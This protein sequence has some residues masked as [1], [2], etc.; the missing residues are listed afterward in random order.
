[1]NLNTAK[2]SNDLKNFTESTERIKRL[3]DEVLNAIPEIC[4]ERGLIV[5]QA[6]LEL[7]DL[8]VPIKRA[9]ILERILENMTISIGDDELIVGNQARK[10]RAAPLFPEYSVDWIG[11]ELDSF[12]TRPADQF[13]VYDNE[14]KLIRDM[15]DYW[16]GKTNEDAQNELISEEYRLAEEMGVLMGI[17]IRI[18]GH[19]HISASH[20]KVMKRGLRDIA[21]EAETRIKDLDLN[22]PEGIEKSSFLQAVVI[23]CNA[24][25]NFALRYADL[26]TEMSKKEIDMN[27]KKELELIAKNCRQVPKR[28]PTNFYEAVQTSW[29][30]Q[31][32]LQI[33]G[34]GHSI[35]LGRFDQYTHPFYKKSIEANEIDAKEAQELIACMFIKMKT[36]NKVRAWEHAKYATGYPMY[37]NLTIGGQTS[38]GEDAV[39]EVTYLCINAMENVRFPEPN[40]IARYWSGSS[41]DY[42]KKCVDSISLGFGMPAMLNDEIIIPSLLGRGVKRIDAFN[43]GAVGCIEVSIPGKWGYR[44]YGMTFTSF[45]KMFELM[46]TNGRA[47]GT[48]NVLFQDGKSLEEC[49]SYEELMVE[50]KRMNDVFAKLAVAHDHIVD[51]CKKE[52]PEIFMSTLVD[53][54][55]VR[56]KPILDGG[57]IYDMNSGVQIGL[58]NVANSLAVI[59]KLV[60]EEKKFTTSEVL[61]VIE[62]NFEGQNG[63]IIRQI[64]KN[65]VPKYGNDDDYVDDIAVEVYETYMDIVEELKNARYGKGP[66]GGKYYASTVTVSANVPA[67]QDVGATPDGRK[68]GEPCAE[69]ASPNS[70]TDIKGPTSVMKSITKIPTIRMTGGQ[71]LNLKFSPELLVNDS[72]KWKLVALLRG[73]SKLKGWHVQ[74]NTISNEI[75]RNAQKNPKDYKNL[76]VRVAGYCALFTDLD[77]DIQNEIINRTEHSQV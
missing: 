41:D 49:N 59:K 69:G 27:R 65:S 12:E 67:G 76:M 30:I 51:T 19:G 46:L 24:V 35:S 66:I 25:I 53:D 32:V 23:G 36:I 60:F 21:K 45:I 56:G 54:C 43:Y 40:L 13:R 14:K 37:Q 77:E 8:P 9:K 18:G 5:T 22:S 50:W 72:G 62:N 68:A 52:I 42:L 75:L 28:P 4:I 7:G 31:L 3:K 44:C 29:F 11:E 20:E 57:A 1:M 39:N 63:E 10:M 74:F 61:K 6:D 48:D 73:F 26:A 16:H 47:Y 34:N 38:D 17:H 71:L 55:I 58:A 33:E 2:Y 15:V 70:G 64:F